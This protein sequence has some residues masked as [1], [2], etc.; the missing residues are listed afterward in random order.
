MAAALIKA[1]P[2]RMLWGTDW[3]HP[4]KPGVVAATDI[5]KPYAVDNGRMLN[6]LGKWAPSQELRKK[7]LVD[8]PK[9]VYG[10]A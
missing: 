10:F 5:T 4:G 3:P 1:N 9:E 6:L 2:E 7:I 8:N